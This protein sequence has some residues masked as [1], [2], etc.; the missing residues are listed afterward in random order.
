MPCA[1]FHTDF[2]ASVCTQIKLGTMKKEL[3]YNRFLNSRLRYSLVFTGIL[4]MNLLM[5]DPSKD[6]KG[7]NNLM[8]TTTKTANNIVIVHGA[9]ADGSGYKELYK[10]L[11]K[12]GFNVTIVQN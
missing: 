7:K 2:S 11:T 8:E 10:I 9:F 6:V 12:K 3:K 4:F 5:T 1:V